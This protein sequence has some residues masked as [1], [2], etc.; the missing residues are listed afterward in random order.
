MGKLPDGL[1]FDYV[2]SEEV[3]VAHGIE[4]AGY[5]ADE[6]A[7]LDAFKYRHKQVPE[8]FMGAF[9]PAADNIKRTLVCYVNATLSSSPRMTHDSMLINDPTGHSVCIH[10]LCVPDAYRHRGIA[11]ALLKEYLQ[12]LERANTA[13][14]K[15]KYE[16]AQL[17]AHDHLRGMYEGAGFKYVGK[18]EVVH[19]SEPWV[20][21][22]W[23]A[24][25]PAQSHP[26]PTELTPPQHIT[27]GLWEALQSSSRKKRPEGKLLSAFTAVNDVAWTDEKSGSEKPTNAYDLLCPRD[28]CGSVVLK[29]G[30]ATLVERESVQMEPAE[31]P[32]PHLTVLPTPPKLTHWWLVT[33]SPMEFENIGFSREVK[34][35]QKQL[36]LL[37]CADCDIGPLGWTEPGGNEFWVSSVRVRYRT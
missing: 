4:L 17:I 12:R 23:V 9:V 29:K 15:I 8:L 22:Q 3:E 20:E 2:T 32:N 28:G 34:T 26:V 27:A 30:H 13:L 21:L 1:F 7:T 36:K 10:A 18:S 6:A 19:G 33:P 14:E 25:S 37:I 35:E 5:P 31:Q 11:T 24:P 16:R